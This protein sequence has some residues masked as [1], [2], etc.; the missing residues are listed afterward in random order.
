MEQDSLKLTLLGHSYFS[1]TPL[2]LHSKLTGVGLYEWSVSASCV[3]RFIRPIVVYYFFR[4]I[5]RAAFNAINK[6]CT[7][8]CGWWLKFSYGFTCKLS[9]C[10]AQCSIWCFLD[11]TTGHTLDIF[12]GS[13]SMDISDLDVMEKAIYDHFPVF[14]RSEGS[15]DVRWDC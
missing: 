6:Y 1:H 7:A 2:T 13:D 12:A 11:A 3:Y 4:R 9:C 5:W 14:W 8:S 15:V 10:E